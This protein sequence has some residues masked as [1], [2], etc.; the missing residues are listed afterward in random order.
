[1]AKQKTG[2]L[3]I[4]KGGNVFGPMLREDL[5]R[6]LAARK[7]APSDQ[8]SVAGAPWIAVEEH[9]NPRAPDQEPIPERCLQV[10]KGR[11]MFGPMTRQ[12]VVDLA[13]SGR[14]DD[15]DLIS[16]LGGPWMRLADFFAAP[17]RPEEV[18]EDDASLVEL[19]PAHALEVGRF[20]IQDLLEE[21][22]EAPDIWY[23]RV[24][25]IHSSPLQKWHIRQL[26]QSREIT[27]D[28]P[29]RNASWRAEDWR[30]IG[31]VRELAA[32]MTRS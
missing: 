4:L 10:L 3:R 5:E 18:E 22:R 12:E 30:R 9:L 16:A 21:G 1:M 15:E 8:V 20:R 31:D 27:L 6:L 32:E 25:G 28:C 11:R 26:Y 24:R 23:I 29:V 14:I 19:L 13:A 7:I 17:I 2:D